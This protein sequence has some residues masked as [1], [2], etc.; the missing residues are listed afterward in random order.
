MAVVVLLAVIVAAGARLIVLHARVRALQRD[1]ITDPLTGTFNRR[2]M[3][4][5]LA[6]TVERHRRSGDHAS[7]LLI[8]VDR[9]KPLNDAAGHAEG[10]RVLHA[11]AD[12]LHRRLR[13]VD[14]LFRFGGDEFVV[15]LS[16]ARLPGA[17]GVAEELRAAIECARL[18]GVT[19]VSVSIGVAE[20]AY[21]Q[22]AAEWLAAADAALY[23]AKKGG[24]NRVAVS[25]APPTATMERRIS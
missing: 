3:H 6:T 2:H 25:A 7:L 9:F 21:E 23:R 14:A 8:D 12:A 4:G 18:G 11:V 22:P 24:R 19:P 16:G 15:L 5:V 20:L 10:D 13:K 17:R 1:A